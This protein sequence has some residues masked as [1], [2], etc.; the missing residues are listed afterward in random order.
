MPDFTSPGW[1]LYIGA[2]TI[3][4]LLFCLVLLF[5]NSRRPAATSDNTT[6]HV[7]DD[8]LREANNPL[9]LWWMGLFVLT[10]ALSAVY[11]LWYPGLGSWP[12]TGG[13]TSTGQ[14]QA[15]RSALEAEQSRI[16]AAY[17]PKSP[18]ALIDDPGAM[19]IGERL[20]MNNCAQCHGSDGRGAKGFP[21]LAD[22]DW[23]Y[24]G[25]AEAVRESIAVG[26]NGT[27]PPMAAAVGSAVDVE[28]LAHYVRSLSGLA[29]D[30][31]KRE[32]GQKSFG[33]CAACHGPRGEGM[34]ALGAPNLTDRVWLYGSSVEDIVATI[35]NG[36]SNRMPAHADKLTEGQI[37]VLTGYVLSLS[38]R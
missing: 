23:L 34:A 21:N 3:L 13:W 24:G 2:I 26:R 17:L 36:R 37:H 5:A 10:V 7:W 22:A 19:A 1:S 11:L 28:R 9:P 29:V 27:M 18:E 6:G 15:E 12:G 16:F 20:F 25:G 32:L 33:A 14:Y 8:D 31:V 35:V 4:S 30:P 38:R